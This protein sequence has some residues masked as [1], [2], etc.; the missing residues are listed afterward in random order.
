MICTLAALTALSDP[1]AARD[2]ATRGN[3]NETFAMPVLRQATK[4]SHNRYICRGILWKRILP[5]K[6]ECV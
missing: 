6:A 5:G 4:R 3:E 1:L 2:G